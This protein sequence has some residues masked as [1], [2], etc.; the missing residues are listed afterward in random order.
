MQK[1]NY[2]P[3]A[4]LATFPAILILPAPIEI[5]LEGHWPNVVSLID[6]VPSQSSAKQPGV[7][8]YDGKVETWYG[9]QAIESP[10]LFLVCIIT[11][12]GVKQDVGA[13]DGIVKHVAR[14]YGLAALADYFK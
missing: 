9:I 13:F 3:P 12:C 5:D 6:S 1:R 14:I 10:S 8:F 7:K 11:N 2:A 4:G